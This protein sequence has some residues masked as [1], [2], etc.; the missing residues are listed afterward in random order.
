MVAKRTKK[1]VL[2]NRSYKND[3]NLANHMITKHSADE[4]QAEAEA[5]DGMTTPPATQ[6]YAHQQKEQ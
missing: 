4:T 5:Q 3:A 6:T 1:C 2:C